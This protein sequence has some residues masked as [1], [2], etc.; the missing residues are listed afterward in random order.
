MKFR[1]KFHLKSF[2]SNE[3]KGYNAT[4]HDTLQDRIR[5]LKNYER[6]TFYNKRSDPDRGN[7]N[8]R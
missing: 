1:K 5:H 8:D 6:P 7:R 2:T 4:W 3:Y